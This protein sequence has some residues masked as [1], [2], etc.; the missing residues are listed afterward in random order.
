[1]KYIII[2]D[3]VTAMTKPLNLFCSESTLNTCR[4]STQSISPFSS[5]FSV[6]DNGRPNKLLINL[7][8]QKR[9]LA[10]MEGQIGKNASLKF[11]H[12]IHIQT[13]CI[14]LTRQI[15][16]H[17]IINPFRSLQILICKL[18]QLRALALIFKSHLPSC[19]H[20]QLLTFFQLYLICTHYTNTKGIHRNQEEIGLEGI[21][22]IY[23][24]NGRISRFCR[25]GRTP[26]VR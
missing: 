11:L 21:F 14:W 25:R 7:A 3:L 2:S 24:D 26:S 9:G 4:I 6:G 5:I 18:Y 8:D 23:R 17:L 20:T 10:P 19:T 15:I 12:Q 22:I 1:M 16:V 13:L